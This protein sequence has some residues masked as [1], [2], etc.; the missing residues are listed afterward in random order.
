MGDGGAGEGHRVVAAIV[1][2]AAQVLLCHRSP[3]RAWYPDVWDLPGGHVVSGET[4]GHALA[5]ELR[6]ELGI[7]I[8]LPPEPAFARL[9]AADF[10]C[11]IW[12]VSE[13]T[14]TPSNMAP[15]E[16]DDVAWW[17]SAA[18]GGLTLPHKDY[19][20]LIRRALA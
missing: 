1:I 8:A 9:V 11:R 12:I 6:E 15:Q 13:W 19:P 18:I 2:R 7:S 10:D 14:G 5:R 17:S 20:A 4:P 16:H 3:D